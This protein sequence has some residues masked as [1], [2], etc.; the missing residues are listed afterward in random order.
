VG[1]VC[2]TLAL[3]CFDCGGYYYINLFVLLHMLIISVVNAIYACV[4]LLPLFAV[5]AECE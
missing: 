2:V 5:A 3:V 4:L 1:V